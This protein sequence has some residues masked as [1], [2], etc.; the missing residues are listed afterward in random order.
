MQT[1]VNVFLILRHGKPFKKLLSK[2]K[3]KE[4]AFKSRSQN[5]KLDSCFTPFIKINSRWIVDLN[6]TGR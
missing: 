3:K 2:K 1:F 4:I 6:I 5:L